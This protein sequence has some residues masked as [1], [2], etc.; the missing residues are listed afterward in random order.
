MPCR[1][2]Q[3]EKAQIHKTKH[4]IIYT[5][6]HIDTKKLFLHENFEEIQKVFC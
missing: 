3:Q 6:L 5:L 1:N 2:S 4:P